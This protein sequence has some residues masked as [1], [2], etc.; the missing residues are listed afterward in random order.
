[1]IA[2][3]WNLYFCSASIRFYFT[4]LE[5]PWTLSHCSKSPREFLT[6]ALSQLSLWSGF[7]QLGARQLKWIKLELV[8]SL[9]LACGST[10]RVS[11]RFCV[12]CHYMACVIHEN[13]SSTENS[14][15]RVLH[16][17]RCL[18]SRWIYQY[19]C[20]PVFGRCLVGTTGV[21]NYNFH[22]FSQ[23]PNCLGRFLPNTFDFV[24]RP[25]VLRCVV[26][27]SVP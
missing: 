3:D 27:D 2:T 13:E 19:R 11:E 1:L 16:F 10:S 25:V 9:V 26:R 22:G 17:Y 14:V 6:A 12:R 4:S 21:V 24:L 18:Q 5:P 23:T 15:L 7:A 8:L 20:R